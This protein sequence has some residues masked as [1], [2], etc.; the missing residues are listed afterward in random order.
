MKK[1]IA[2]RCFDFVVD[3]VVVD[4][5]VAVEVLVSVVVV[6]VEVEVE[7]VVGVVV[8]VDVVV[9]GEVVGLFVSFIG[10]EFQIFSG[11]FKKIFFITTGIRRI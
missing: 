1:G 10:S 6:L 3:S 11:F 2:V 5:S 4:V 8:V 7:E 9:V